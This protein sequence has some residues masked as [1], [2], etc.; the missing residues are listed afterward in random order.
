MLSRHALRDVEMN[1]FWSDHYY[2]CRSLIKNGLQKC[3][4]LAM[5]D[6]KNW[7]WMRAVLTCPILVGNLT[8]AQM[9]GAE[10]I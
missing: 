8:L 5:H 7:R 6:T 10:K 2:S 4:L 9:Q 1:A 3:V